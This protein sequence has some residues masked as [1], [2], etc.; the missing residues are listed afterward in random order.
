MGQG[1]TLKT[2]CAAG[3]KAPD[4]RAGGGAP[5]M[6]SRLS[7][8]ATCGFGVWTSLEANNR[9][10]CP[11]SADT[12]LK[13]FLTLL[14]CS[15]HLLQ[16]ALQASFASFCH[17]TPSIVFAFHVAH[18]RLHDYAAMFNVPEIDRKVKLLKDHPVC[19]KNMARLQPSNWLWQG[20]KSWNRAQRRRQQQQQQQLQ[21]QQGLAAQAVCSLRPGC[22]HLCT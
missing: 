8:L 4:S 1:E 11:R 16:S 10:S 19:Y 22:M 9:L 14:C 20:G 12:A 3:D 13:P 2:Q 5:E 21:Q 18:V 15:A 7:T 6:G 17:C